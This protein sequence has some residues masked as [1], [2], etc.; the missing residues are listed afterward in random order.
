[1]DAQTER[2]RRVS[3]TLAAFVLICFFL[4]WVELSCTGLKDSVSGYDLARSTSLLWLIPA[5][6]LAVFLLGLTKLI[7]DNRPAVFALAASVGGGISAFLMYRERLTSNRS[8]G[9]IAAQMT[10]WYWVG[11]VAALGLIAS[12]F[13]FYS[14]R[15]RSP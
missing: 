12:A 14:A 3:V 10:V 6:M 9:L 11:I 15:S 2:P 4:P 5:S 1:M 7:W 13:V 8:A